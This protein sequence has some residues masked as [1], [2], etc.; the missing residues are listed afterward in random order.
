ML[1]GRLR[2]FA[3]RSGASAVEFALVA[4]ILITLV[5][6]IIEF[7]LVL[8]TYTEAGSATRDVARRIATGRLVSTNAQSEVRAQLPN[9]VRNWANVTANQTTPGTAATNQITVTVTFPASKATPTTYL[10]F[11]YGSLTLTNTTTMQ[12]EI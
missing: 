6:G 2:D 7:S 3:D 1:K 10:G 4:S 12:Q 8:Y 5:M 9:W 11:A